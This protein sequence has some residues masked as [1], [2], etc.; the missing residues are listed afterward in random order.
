MYSSA[1]GPEAS[2]GGG[3]GGDSVATRAERV[4][5]LLQS[6]RRRSSLPY[7]IVRR[8]SPCRRPWPL[9]LGTTAARAYTRLP[10]VRS[11][12]PAKLYLLAVTFQELEMPD[13]GLA[14]EAVGLKRSTVFFAVRCTDWWAFRLAKVARQPFT[15][16]RRH[17]AAILDHV[18]AT[19]PSLR[20]QKR[21]RSALRHCRN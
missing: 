12:H 9:K 5:T 2:G 18:H 6:K 7:C 15:D 10:R 13:G 1:S 14:Y 17:T 19:T 20:S 16:D 11:S 21:C 8:D 3:G 4:H